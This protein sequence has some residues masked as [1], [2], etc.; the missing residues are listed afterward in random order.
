MSP[1]N[2]L[3]NKR[4]QQIRKSLPPNEITPMRVLYDYVKYA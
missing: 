3:E 4:L 1:N 2:H